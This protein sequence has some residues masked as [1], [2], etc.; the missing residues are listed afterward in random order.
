MVFDTGSSNLWVPSSHCKGLDIACLLHRRYSATRSSTYEADGRPF[1]IKYGSGSMSGVVRALTAQP[2]ECVAPPRR[3]HGRPLPTQLSRDTL[4]LGGLTLPN[5][6]FAEA[7]SEP[8]LAFVLSQFDGILGLAYPKLSVG[9]M[10]PIFQVTLAP[11]RGGWPCAHPRGMLASI[12]YTPSQA[13]VDAGQISKPQ[14][15]FWLSK[16]PCAPPRRHVPIATLTPTPPRSG[17]EPGG[18]LLLGGADPSYYDGPLHTVPVTRRAYWQFDLD[19]I[20]LGDKTM[21]KHTSAIADSGTSLIAGP[22]SEVKKLLDALG[23]TKAEG[24]GGQY[25]IECSKARRP[26][27]RSRCGR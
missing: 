15:A 21:V 9:G 18:A 17:A 12:R 10:Q 14:F 7:T 25:P 19:A 1:S 20:S 6:T 27:A 4:R 11:S 26:A 13:L 3:A 23:A 2:A 24:A 5:A 8:G 16:T 22:T